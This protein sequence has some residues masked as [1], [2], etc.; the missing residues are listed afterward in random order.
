LVSIWL[1]AMSVMMVPRLAE[2][3]P[4]EPIKS[5]LTFLMDGIEI[6]IGR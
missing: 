4:T 2:A 6:G 3:L 1:N 5:Q